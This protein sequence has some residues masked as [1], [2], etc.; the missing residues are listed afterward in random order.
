MIYGQ[1]SSEDTEFEKLKQKQGPKPSRSF[2]KISSM[3][4]TSQKAAIQR[5]YSVA[6][7]YS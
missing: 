2:C 4:G 3:N 5:G 1:K 7:N 6:P